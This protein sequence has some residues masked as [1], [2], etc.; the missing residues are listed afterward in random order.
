MHSV[1]LLL[2][3][4]FQELRSEQYLSSRELPRRFPRVQ[5]M[6]KYDSAGRAVTALSIAGAN[7]PLLAQLAAIPQKSA[8]RLRESFISRSK[9]AAV[10]PPSV[11]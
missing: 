1:P 2:V 6:A 11:T 10:Q 7:A 4:L 9:S 8:S 5:L 3:N